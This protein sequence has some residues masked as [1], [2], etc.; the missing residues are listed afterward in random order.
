[1]RSGLKNNTELSIKSHVT[2]H[3][4]LLQSGYSVVTVLLQSCYSLVRVYVIKMTGT[5]KCTQSLSGNFNLLIFYV[6]EK[7]GNN[8]QK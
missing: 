6:H 5:A 4:V 2:V 8:K 3:F 7:F 1:M